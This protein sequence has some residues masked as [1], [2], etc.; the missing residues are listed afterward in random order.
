M[1]DF[2]ERD[3][4]PT[5]LGLGPVRRP[6]PS[7]PPPAERGRQA[8]HHDD[9]RDSQEISA[10]TILA[11]LAKQAQEARDAKA[12]AAALRRALGATRTASA[13]STGS[14]PAPDRKAFLTLLYSF[15]GALVLLMGAATAWLG[16]HTAKVEDKIDK[17]EEQRKADKAVVAPLPEKVQTAERDAIDCREWARLTADYDRQVFG[18]LGVIIPQPENAKPVEPIKTR[19][20]LHRSNSVTGAPVLEVLTPQPPLP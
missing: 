10:D 2:A 8:S 14:A 9:D 20:P 13:E 6:V 11:E 12:E 18:K 17:T 4:E 19:A 3:P 1:P 16:A 15:G 5:S 7:N